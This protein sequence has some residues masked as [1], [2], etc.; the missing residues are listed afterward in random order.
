MSDKVVVMFAGRIAQAADPETI[1]DR[2]ASRE[3]AAFVGQ[4]NILACAAPDTAGAMRGLR[5]A[6][7]AIPIPDALPPGGFA[8][9]DVMARPEAIGVVAA[10]DPR[11]HLTGRVVGRYYHGAFVVYRVA[12]ADTVVTAQVAPPARF[13]EGEP[14]GLVLDAA[15]LWPLKVA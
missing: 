5:T 15:R 10:D 3:V 2:P 13:G 12:L 7:G 9:V 1:Y 6:G 11:A 14:V 8:N 4:A